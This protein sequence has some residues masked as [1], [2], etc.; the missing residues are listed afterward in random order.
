MSEEELKKEIYKLR[1]ELRV[2]IRGVREL[3]KSLPFSPSYA[4][5]KMTKLEKKMRETPVIRMDKKQLKDTLRELQYTRSLKSSS[6]EGI[7]QSESTLEN[8]KQ[9]QTL[10]KDLQDKFWD[11]Y[12]VFYEET[13]GL[14]ELYKYEIFS[15]RLIDY[16]NRDTS[17]V[18]MAKQIA[19]IWEKLNETHPMKRDEDDE[20]YE[21]S[22]EERKEYDE[23][24]EQFKVQ[25]FGSRL[26]N[27][28]H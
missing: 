11:I 28:F 18:V 5:E 20:Y 7:K 27:I 22:R 1:R 25:L 19:D 23:Q 13:K 21:M 15:S 17:A 6:V 8:L 4:T 10:S 24:R 3:K 26:K 16:V 12:R 9:V 14:A 2:D